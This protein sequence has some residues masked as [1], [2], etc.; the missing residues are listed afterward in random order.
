MPLLNPDLKGVVGKGPL[1][2][3]TYQGT[4]Q[5]TQGPDYG[6]GRNPRQE[7]NLQGTPLPDVKSGGKGAPRNPHQQR[8]L[9]LEEAQFIQAPVDVEAIDIPKGTTPDLDRMAKTIARIG[10]LP[11]GKAQQMAVERLTQA[12]TTPLPESHRT[13]REFFS[14]ENIQRRMDALL[15]T[16]PRILATVFPEMVQVDQA[17]QQIDLQREQGNAQ[18]DI[19]RQQLQLQRAGL[20]VDLLQF[21]QNMAIKEA[22]GRAGGVGGGG[23]DNEFLGLLKQFN[24]QVQRVT[25]RSGEG[26]KGRIRPKDV[27]TAVETDISSRTYFLM[28]L[29]NYGI[30]QGIITEQELAMAGSDLTKLL[31]SRPDLLE[32]ALPNMIALEQAQ[33][34]EQGGGVSLSTSGTNLDMMADPQFAALMGQIFGGG[35]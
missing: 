12:L 10:T 1:P 2:K 17:Q 33:S 11:K 7:H 23:V 13:D 31:D 29:R 5:F 15:A 19:Q 27:R 8:P 4:A 34:G 16:D 14:P 24:E 28:Y 20:V 18:L 26:R 6:G 22:M 3:S 30:P 32:F 25:G 35:Q 21:Q 9:S